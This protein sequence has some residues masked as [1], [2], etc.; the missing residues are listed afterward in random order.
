MTVPPIVPRIADWVS[1]ESAW[2]SPSLSKKRTAANGK[3]ERCGAAIASSN[4]E[5]PI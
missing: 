3:G 5:V 1:L 2:R 4:I